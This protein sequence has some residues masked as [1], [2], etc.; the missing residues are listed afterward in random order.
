RTV[1]LDEAK[2]L[3]ARV[4]PL[5]EDN[6][7]VKAGVAATLFAACELAK[8]D[9]V[10]VLFSGLGSEELFAG[11]DRH[12]KSSD[13]NKECLS[14]LLKIYERDL[15]RDDVLTMNNMIE[16]RLPFLD[17]KLV[18]KAL[19]ISPDQKIQGIRNKIIL[20]EAARELG[21][22][23]EFAE[24]PKK[25]AQ[26]GSKFDRALEKLSKREGYATKSAFLK[27]FYTPANVKLAALWSGGKDSAFAAY[28][29]TLQNYE[30]SC[31][32]TL[33]ST[34]PDSYM[35]H[36]P[37]IDIAPLHAEAMGIP[38]ILQETA[39]EKEKEL[40]DL[41][42]ALQ[43]AKEQYRVEGVVTG[44]LFSNYQRDRIE[45][46]CDKLG[47]KI[48]A[49]LWHMDQEKELRLL[50]DRGFSIMLSSVAA[51]GLDASLLGRKL[52]Q[53]D[54]DALVRIAKKHGINVAGEGGET[55]SLVLD[56]PLFKKRVEIVESEIVKESE[57]SAQF[58]VKKAVL[59]EKN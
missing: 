56:C 4:V 19:T 2:Q 55:E 6:N 38:L 46:V 53:K 25:A 30:L 22:P 51:Q 35:F 20:R 37:N 39:G 33:K 17:R 1:S 50:L 10:R 48:F 9:G 31:L 43:Q 49:P 29:M 7:V 15:Y 59:V 26:Y 16:L 45:G 18:A 11:Y 40:E 8:Q 57:H 23:E 13:V 58:I 3:F 5:I 36:T 21:I 42:K 27:Q 14:G 41:E 54:V 24:R 52:T 34:N 12:K 32:V 47:L 28:V 44:A